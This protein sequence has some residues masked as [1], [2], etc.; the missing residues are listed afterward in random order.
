[1]SKRLQRLAAAL[2][3]LV[4]L[5]LPVAAANATSPIGAGL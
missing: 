4:T 5:A 2:A 3:P 1:M